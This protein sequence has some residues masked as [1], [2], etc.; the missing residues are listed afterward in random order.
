MKN[1]NTKFKKGFT[2]VEMIV[3][4]GLFTIVLFISSSAFLAVLNA[5]RKSRFTRIATDSLNISLEDM[6]RRIKTGSAYYCG[7]KVIG[8]SSLTNT[9]DC[10]S[11]TTIVFTE[12]DGATRTFYHFDG[13]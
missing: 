6:A 13:T 8:M 7:D 12:Q 5:D 2:L 3:S 4:I 11:G 1:D 9:M 10:V